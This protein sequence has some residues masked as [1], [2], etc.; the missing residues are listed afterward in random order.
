MGP[1]GEY[2]TQRL[3]TRSLSSIVL[4]FCRVETLPFRFY[5]HKRIYARLF[6][7]HLNRDDWKW[8]KFLT[9]QEKSV[10]FWVLYGHVLNFFTKLETFLEFFA[11]LIH[12]IGQFC[13]SIAHVVFSLDIAWHGS[14]PVFWHVPFWSSLMA[15]SNGSP[16][17][18]PHTRNPPRSVIRIGGLACLTLQPAAALVQPFPQLTYGHLSLT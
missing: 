15:D 2:A 9:E 12:V 6:L 17:R 4:D 8:I 14:Y 10:Y 13:L 16:P 1:I 18:R 11:H 5:F 7:Q 3:W